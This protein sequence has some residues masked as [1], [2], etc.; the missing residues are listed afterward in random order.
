MNKNSDELQMLRHE[1]DT[2]DS[3]L[4]DLLAKRADFVKAI[5]NYKRE[6]NVP[7]F[8]PLRWNEVMQAR[9]IEAGKIGL[10]PEF[11]REVFGL[12]HQYSL[13]LQS[14]VKKE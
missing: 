7:L 9:M 6:H 1:I 10:S 5:G 12:I 3:L 11:I 2:V 4:L 14:D 8:D 13:S